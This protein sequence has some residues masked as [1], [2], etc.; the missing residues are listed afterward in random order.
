VKPFL[1]TGS[2]LLKSGGRQV[3]FGLLAA[4]VTFGWGKLAGAAIH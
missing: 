3:L 2:P 1:T 4:G